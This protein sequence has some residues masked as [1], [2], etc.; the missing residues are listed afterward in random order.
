MALHR[1]VCGLRTYAVTLGCVP[2]ASVKGLGLFGGEGDFFFP[3]K[4]IVI[5]SW[6]KHSFFLSLHGCCFA[7]NRKFV[8]IRFISSFKREGKTEE[9]KAKS[10]G[11]PDEGQPSLNNEQFLETCSVKYTTRER[12]IL[13]E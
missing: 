7:Q 9:R 1:R 4:I 2:F 11:T 6:G 3:G 5:A 12:R 8:I 10:F 13:K